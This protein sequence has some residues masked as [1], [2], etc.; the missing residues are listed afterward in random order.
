M[1][2]AQSV[3]PGPE[4][5]PTQP[6]FRDDITNQTF[7]TGQEPSK[8]FTETFQSDPLKR[9]W[10]FDFDLLSIGRE[11]IPGFPP[12]H[13][14]GFRGLQLGSHQLRLDDPTTAAVT[15]AGDGLPWATTMSLSH[16]LARIIHNVRRK[17]AT[18]ALIS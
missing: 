18:R 5:A 1:P 4:D 16:A 7:N 8:S 15:V 13:E 2:D 11:V 6:C 9:G 12:R 3:S 14:P 10:Y 17:D